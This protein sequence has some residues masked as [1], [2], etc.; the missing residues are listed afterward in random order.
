MAVKIGDEVTLTVTILKVLDD[1]M[2]SVS[3]SAQTLQP[4]YQERMAGLAGC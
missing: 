1:G 4:A 2:A 3:I